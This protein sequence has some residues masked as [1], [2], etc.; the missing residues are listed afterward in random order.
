MGLPEG[1]Q[2]SAMAKFKLGDVVK[3]ERGGLG[4][5]RAVFVNKDGV[6]MYAV[7]KDGT[8][9]FLHEPRLSPEETIE[10]AA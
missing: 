7:E 2:D 10:L 8:I 6:Q 4:V 5:V 1:L 9:D 3:K